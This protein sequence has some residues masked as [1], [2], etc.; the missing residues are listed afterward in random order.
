MAVEMFTHA[1]LD[2]CISINIK[3]FIIIIIIMKQACFL[4]LFLLQIP[5]RLPGGEK[6]ALEMFTKAWLDFYISTTN[7]E[8]QKMQQRIH[9]DKNS[10]FFHVFRNALAVGT[11]T[12]RQVWFATRSVNPANPK[13]KN[14]TKTS[15]KKTSK[16]ASKKKLKK[17]TPKKRNPSKNSKRKPNNTQKSLKP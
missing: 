8:F 2:V 9:A 17:T 4:L 11:L 5:Y 1:W 6:V 7:S 10:A 15:Q 12:S 16:K 14:S 3:E 13:E